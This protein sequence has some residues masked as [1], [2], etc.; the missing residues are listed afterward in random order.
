MSRRKSIIGITVSQSALLMMRAGLLRTSKSRNC[1]NCG[2]I[3]SRFAA[4]RSLLC[5]LAFLTLAARVADQP[6]SRRPPKQSGV[7]ETLEPC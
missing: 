6:R 7:P 1:A 4:I 2:L 5:K 3:F